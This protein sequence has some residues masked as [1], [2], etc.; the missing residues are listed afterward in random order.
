MKMPMFL[1]PPHRAQTLI[2]KM[3]NGILTSDGRLH[4]SIQINLRPI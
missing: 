4:Y 1:P 3:T 2:V